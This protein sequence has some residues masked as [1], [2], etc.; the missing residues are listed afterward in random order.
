MKKFFKWISMMFTASLCLGLMLLPAVTATAETAEAGNSYVYYAQAED[1][2]LTAYSKT[3]ISDDK[4]DIVIEKGIQTSIIDNE[5]AF[6]LAFQNGASGKIYIELTMD[7]SSETLRVVKIEGKEIINLDATFV[8]EKITFHLD[9]AGTYAVIDVNASVNS[10]FEWYHALMIAGFV[11]SV[12]LC[13]V[14]V[15]RRKK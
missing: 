6:S 12:A 4:N 8:D 3:A 11:A 10:G 14:T 7:A 9:Q 2:I 15:V 1:G 13:V 5:Y